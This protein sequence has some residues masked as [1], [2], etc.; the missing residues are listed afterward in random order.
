MYYF[1][2]FW[3]QETLLFT[4]CINFVTPSPKRM[5]WSKA[6][7]KEKIKYSTKWKKVYLNF[8]WIQYGKFLSVSLLRQLNWSHVPNF[9]KTNNYLVPKR[10]SPCSWKQLTHWLSVASATAIF[11][12]NLE[13]NK[14]CFD[15]FDGIFFSTNFLHKKRKKIIPP[16]E[17]SSGSAAFFTTISSI[18]LI[19]NFFI[20]CF[21][22]VQIWTTLVKGL[23]NNYERLKL[24]MDW[25]FKWFKQG[26]I[27]VFLCYI[28]WLS[29][30]GGTQGTAKIWK[31]IRNG[32]WR[33]FNSNHISH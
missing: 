6:F 18:S 9:W 8:L 29:W 19:L 26:V 14:N 7:I 24:V 17:R 4:C 12:I 30:V 13:N 31:I 27:L 3:I 32:K 22:I 23:K 15:R 2:H 11:V 25:I 20:A 33:N 16:I 10:A 5:L 21:S 28:W 1:L